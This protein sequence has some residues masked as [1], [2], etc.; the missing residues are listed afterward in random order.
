MPVWHELTGPWRASGDLVVVGIA[1]EQ[2]PARC[3]LYAQWQALDWPILWDP[4]NLTGSNAVP[5]IVAVDEHG[6]V[7]SVAPRPSTFEQEF[8]LADFAAPDTLPL[9]GEPVCAFAT[10]PGYGLEGSLAFAAPELDAAVERAE[11]ARAAD[12]TSGAAAFRAGVTRRLRF[13]SPSARPGDFQ[14]ALDAWRHALDVDPN[15]Y[16]WRRR[17]QQY[18]PRMDKPYDF[19]GWV[20]EAQAAVRA[21]GEEPVG[22]VAE[23]TR[24][25]LAK[26]STGFEEGGGEN[27]D[28]AGRIR[29]DTG[30][31]IG[32]ESAVAFDTSAARAQASVH[33]TFTP[34]A[35][36]RVHWNHEAGPPL[37][38]W[39]QAVDGAACRLERNLF[40]VEPTAGVA[41]TDDPLRL[42]FEV[43]L[44]DGAD[45][46]VLEAYALYFVCEDAE[47]VCSYL[48]Q[49]FRI[50]LERP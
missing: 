43:R 38:V 45:G 18:G 40:T 24:A 47:G 41:V 14:A 21:R 10:C 26:P 34:N 11:T 32:V 50:E 13:D 2:H 4:Y 7:R 28:P 29:R 20:E 1:Q 8:L 48:R 6:I 25:E 44:A 35:A 12:P 39:V 9:P 3:R 15:Q 19:Y 46:A 37:R 42:G 23:L 27:P 36:R 30:E 16:I 5:G 49:D 31:E 17:I 22:L 33:L